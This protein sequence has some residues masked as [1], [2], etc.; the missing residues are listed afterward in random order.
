MKQTTRRDAALL[1]GVT[2]TGML[3]ILLGAC[4]LIAPVRQPGYGIRQK[5]AVCTPQLSVNPNTANLEELMTLPGVGQQKAEA[6]L[7]YRQKNGPFL[8][9]EDMADVPGIT[10]QM[11]KEW[12]D[13]LTLNPE[14]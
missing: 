3:A 8:C 14:F 4:F 2:V 6:I 12:A 1:L 7:D 13:C 10:I 5:E 11:V 9:A